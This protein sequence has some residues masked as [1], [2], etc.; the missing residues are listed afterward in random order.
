M[1]AR[2]EGQQKKDDAAGEPYSPAGNA[3]YGE[4]A[5]GKSGPQKQ[6]ERIIEVGL[7]NDGLT[8][9]RYLYPL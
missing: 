2:R 3:T 7:I 1:C 4:E 8:V 6:A 9:C 5:H